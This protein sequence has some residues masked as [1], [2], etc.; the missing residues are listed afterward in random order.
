VLLMTFLAGRALATP[1]L[2]KLAETLAAVQATDPAGFAHECRPP[3][4]SASDD[5]YF[6]CY[7]D[8]TTQPPASR[9]PA[10]W[11]TAIDLW[12]HAKPH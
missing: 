6:R 10:L 11:E 7:E 2:D 9:R 3:E 5:D 8:T 12:H 1:D 4:L